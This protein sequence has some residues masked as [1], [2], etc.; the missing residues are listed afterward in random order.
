MHTLGMA[1]LCS[2]PGAGSIEEQIRLFA[3]AGF[4]AVF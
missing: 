2:H 4:D 1:F 3:E